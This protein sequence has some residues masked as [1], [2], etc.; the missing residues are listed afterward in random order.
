MQRGRDDLEIDRAVRVG[1][2][3]ELIAAVG[4]RVLHAVFPS[5]DQPRGA[6][7]IGEVDQPLLGGFVVAAGNYAVTSAGAFMKMGEPAEILLLIDQ[8]VLALRSAQSMPP[9]LHRA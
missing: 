5:R 1:E 8:G 2:D 6:V 7:G 3:K 9:D 4:D